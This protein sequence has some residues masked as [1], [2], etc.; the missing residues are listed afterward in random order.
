MKSAL[1][2]DTL[3]ASVSAAA[4]DRAGRPV[5]F[6]DAQAVA[7]DVGHPSSGRVGSW[8]EHRSLDGELPR[9][10]RHQPACEEAS[11]QGEGDDRA[12]AIGR[13]RRDAAGALTG[14]LSSSALLR[15]QI[16]GIV[17][18]DEE[19]PGIGDQPLGAGLDVEHPQCVDRI[20]AAGTA[21]E[22]HPS[23]IA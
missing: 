16:G 14:T 11:G 8:I 5:Q 1:P 19:G 15:G 2:H 20:A 12:L 6:T 21:Q 9:H 3:S 22:H 18:I 13:I 10:A 7:A 23:A 4:G 17:A